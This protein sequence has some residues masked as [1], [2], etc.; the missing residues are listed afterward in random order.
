MSGISPFAGDTALSSHRVLFPESA[1]CDRTL[2]TPS[3]VV[4]TLTPG[5]WRTADVQVGI[6][7]AP[8]AD[9]VEALVR[10]MDQVYSGLKTPADRLIGV[11]AHHHRFVWTHP[12]PDG[13]GRVVRLL[14]QAALRWVGIDSPLWSISRCLANQRTRYYEMLQNPDSPR[15]GDLDGRGNLSE[16]AFVDF[17]TFFLDVCLGQIA[18]M[19][20]FL[21]LE[22]TQQYGGL[23]NRIIASLQYL[24]TSKGELHLRAEAA[25]PIFYAFST[26]EV[27]CTE[28]EKMTGLS[29]EEAQ[30]TLTSTVDHG[31]LRRG[32]KRGNEQAYHFAIPPDGLT[33]LFPGLYGVSGVVVQY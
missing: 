20:Q 23:K 27:T 10:R 21:S 19:R 31:F 26:G 7:V 29:S 2:T 32:P 24:S 6:H 28:F 12:F 25:T 33:L 17:V 30:Q 9:N 14:S 3:G 4:F 5:K 8:P 1:K 15:Q 13:N 22:S 18:L 16:R 11:A